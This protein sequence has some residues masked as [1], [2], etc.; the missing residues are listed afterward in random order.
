MPNKM[1]LHLMNNPDRVGLDPLLKQLDPALCV[2]LARMGNAGYIRGLAETFPNIKWVAA[3]WYESQGTRDNFGTF[4]ESATQREAGEMFF[5]PSIAWEN[6]LNIDGGKMRQFHEGLAGLP[7]VWMQGHNEVGVGKNYV[8]WEKQRT[9]LTRFHYGIGS[10]V[11]NDG[12]GKSEF[13]HFQMYQQL[14]LYPVLLNNGSA[15]GMHAYAGALLE[16]WHGEVQAVSQ[17]G[18]ARPLAKHPREYLNSVPVY[19]AARFN[20]RADGD[21]GS[22]LAFRVLRDHHYINETG[23]GEVPLFITEFGYDD[24]GRQSLTPYY[25]NTY[26]PRGL[27]R[28]R[29]IW[30]EW[31]LSNHEEILGQQMAYADAQ[32]RKVPNVVGAAWFQYGEQN[33]EAWRLFDLKPVQ[34]VAPYLESLKNEPPPV[35]P[36]LPDDGKCWVQATTE[37]VNVREAPAIDSAIVR[38]IE[39]GTLMV[40]GGF[41]LEAGDVAR[42]WY[43]VDGGYV[44]G[45]VVRHTNA[46]RMIVTEPPPVETPS[47]CLDIIMRLFNRV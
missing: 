31:G 44:A 25:S 19:E 21:L 20:D 38:V 29:K 11:I 34:F 9:V 16:L 33:S 24:A 7:N 46:C 12:V 8:D 5:N 36:D 1:G 41:V 13:S 18:E 45:W 22:H 26:T 32:L 35:I 23:G 17:D 6:W 27:V 42:P 39:P 37:R 28:A 10:V 40:S 47:G 4:E 30:D 2:V 43:Q 15:L 3:P 14:G